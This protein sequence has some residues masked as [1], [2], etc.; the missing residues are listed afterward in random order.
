MGVFIIY[1]RID[2]ETKRMALDKLP[3]VTRGLDA[4]KQGP[5][6]G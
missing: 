2:A 1:T 4:P 6:Q 5:K 3:D